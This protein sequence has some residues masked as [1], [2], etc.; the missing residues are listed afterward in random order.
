VAGEARLPNAH[1]ASYL[2]TSA[3]PED[4]AKATPVCA[5]VLTEFQAFEH[6]PLPGG[7]H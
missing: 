3:R 4:E 2:V 6:H 7:A 1:F 5:K